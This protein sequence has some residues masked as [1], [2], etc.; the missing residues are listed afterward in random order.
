MV[1]RSTVIFFVYDFIIVVR[2]YAA[3][4]RQLAVGV[5]YGAA[6]CSFYSS[7]KCLCASYTL[8]VLALQTHSTQCVCVMYHIVV[9][10]D[11][12][13]VHT[14]NT[15]HAYSYILLLSLHK[16]ILLQCQRRVKITG[17]QDFGPPLRVDV[18]HLPR[19]NSFDSESPVIKAYCHEVLASIRKVC[20][21]NP[22]L[23]QSLQYFSQHLN[24]QVS[25]CCCCC[26][27]C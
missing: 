11:V 23:T 7:D 26:C 8:T 6:V 22:M 17:V 18:E 19:G 25:L 21:L 14:G 27:C 4:T 20:K 1:L 12:R 3:V 24:V 15:K 5:L 9:L 2:A 10:V 16:Q 13:S